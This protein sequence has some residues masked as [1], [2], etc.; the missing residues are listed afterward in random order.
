MVYKIGDVLM[1]DFE[2][3]DVKG[4]PGKSGFGIV[5]ICYGHSVGGIQAIKSFQ[6]RFFKDTGVVNAFHR[7]AEVWVKLGKH[8][9]IVRAFG[10]GDVD[11]QPHIIL[12]YIDGG[13]LRD[14]LEHGKL[15]VS[16]SLHLAIQF[17]DG[18]I[19][20][21]S[22][23]LGGGRKGMVHRDIKP[24]NIMLTKEGVLKIT[25]FGLVKALSAPS[26]ERPAGTPEYMSPEQ[27]ET[28]DVDQRS[29]IYSFGIVL[30]EMLTGR[31][32]FPNPSDQTLRF[33]HYKYCHQNV[34][35]TQPR[36]LEPALSKELEEVVLKCLKKNPGDR[37]QNF[38]E[39]KN[40]LM[41]IYLRH[42]RIPP[43]TRNKKEP[44]TAAEWFLKGYSLL[45]LD[46]FTEAI[47]C[48]DRALELNPRF[49]P[50]WSYKGCTLL[51]LGRY[52]E[53]LPCLDRALEIG[54]MYE[55]NKWAQ[56]SSYANTWLYK[57]AT[58]LKLDRF[59]D[60]IKCFN[61]A[62]EFNPRYA[63]AWTGKG[64]ALLELNISD[65]ALVCCDKALEINP[66]FKQALNLK[67]RILLTKFMQD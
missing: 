30:Y 11:D 52:D 58:L 51:K 61:K 36:K 48:L 38:M 6:D 28:M 4:G 54:F 50:A 29:D 40:K 49:A 27:F 25:D 32:P 14:M 26:G 5:Y 12:E 37:C 44:L 45:A 59:D 64:V 63:E 47:E 18:M 16:Q 67:E 24:E 8:E 42:C 17:C 10:V 46:R 55:E 20:A 22:V 65:E 23:D 9:N 56:D 39:L 13:N 53:A 2:V 33:E 41:D 43:E 62:L 57:G 1:H 66:N 35:I 34:M 21:S 15:G 3:I 60:A 7:E 19:Y 31:M